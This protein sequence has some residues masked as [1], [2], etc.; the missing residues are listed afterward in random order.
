MTNIDKSIVQ[1][2]LR[3][4]VH[5]TVSYLQSYSMIIEFRL[6]AGQYVSFYRNIRC[7]AS[8]IDLYY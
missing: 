2:Y 1:K 5:D 6:F 4:L 8:I 7:R 3:H